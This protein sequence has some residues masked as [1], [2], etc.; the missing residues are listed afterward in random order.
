MLGHVVT[1][2]FLKI[3]L[4]RYWGS[5]FWGVDKFVLEIMGRFGVNEVEIYWAKNALWVSV[6]LLGRIDKHNHSLI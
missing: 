6:E 1:T 4:C 2:A 5:R 3:E